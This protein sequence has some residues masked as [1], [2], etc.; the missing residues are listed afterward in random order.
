MSRIL[1][2]EP[3][4]TY[5]EG[6]GQRLETEGYTVTLVSSN[7]EMFRVLETDPDYAAVVGDLG[8]LEAEAATLHQLAVQYSS[9]PVIVTLAEATA[10]TVIQGM[11]AGAFDIFIKPFP[12]DMLVPSLKNAIQTQRLRL[13][14]QLLH[15]SSSR[16]PTASGFAASRSVRR[17][18]NDYDRFV[19]VGSLY[20][21]KHRR[22]AACRGKTIE[23]TPTE[24][25]ILLI[26]AQTTGQVVLFQD[27]V[28]RLQQITLSREEARKLLSAHMS[29]LRTK[30]RQVG[31]DHYL[32]NSRGRGYC[33]DASGGTDQ[34]AARL[35]AAIEPA[36]APGIFWSTDRQLRFLAAWGGRLHVLKVKLDELVGRSLYDL[37]RVDTAMTACVQAHQRALA[38][39][40]VTFEVVW[41]GRHFW[42][43]VEPVYDEERNIIGCTGVGLDMEPLPAAGHSFARD[44]SSL[45]VR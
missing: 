23:L 30:L 40:S 7:D 9:I 22:T 5:R 43:R 28:Y 39:R 8:C 2:V 4:A 29:N 42:S 45:K 3:E 15:E 1:V 6:I 34:T 19:P 10:N 32:V 36:N 14:A 20:L 31:C 33:L 17:P 41:S 38:G 13:R 21:D 44:E 37:A 24:F 27:L 11:R 16:V 18:V 12:V 35:Q 25:E 26:L